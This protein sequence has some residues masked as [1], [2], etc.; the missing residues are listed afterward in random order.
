MDFKSIICATCT[1]LAAASFNA[2]AE[3]VSA[4]DIL[5]S[6]ASS[7]D[8]LYW[9]DPDGS[10]GVDRYEIYADMMTAGGGWTLGVHSLSGS[11][12]STTDMVSNTGVAGLSTGHTRDLTHLAIDRNAEL[13]HRLVDFDGSV[14]FDG[15]Y[16]GNYHGA[17]GDTADWTTLEGNLNVLDHHLGK[18]WSTAA[19][20]VDSYSGNCATMYGTPWYYGNC[21]TTMPTNSGDF[22]TPTGIH[23]TDPILSYS[24]FARELETP[25]LSPVPVPAAAWLF[26][27]ALIGLVGFGRRRA[28]VST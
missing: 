12:A 1:C 5:N 7:V 27:T 9:I 19:N 14:I 21:W 23:H 4:K 8:G 20:D 11:N 28:G 17:L 15:Y 18:S 22:D 24:I 25:S 2:Q 13:R 3:F 6:N 16:T 10:G 26:G